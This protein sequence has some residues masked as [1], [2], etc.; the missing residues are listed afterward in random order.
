MERVPIPA[1]GRRR[2]VG[3]GTRRECFHL[4]EK[5]LGEEEPSVSPGK[6]PAT[7]FIA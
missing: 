6:T 2:I 7:C 5:G 3:F 1:A 4:E